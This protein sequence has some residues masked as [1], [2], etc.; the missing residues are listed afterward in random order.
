MESD[1]D[2]SLKSI[3]SSFVKNTYSFL[4]FKT[5]DAGIY[6]YKFSFQTNL[7]QYVIFYFVIKVK[8]CEMAI[9]EIMGLRIQHG[10]MWRGS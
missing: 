1:L 4:A 2:F 7:F 3:F 8:N 6:F 5:N 9:S 10:K